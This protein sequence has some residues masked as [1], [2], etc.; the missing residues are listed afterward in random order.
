VLVALCM[1]SPPLMPRERRL[2]KRGRNRFKQESAGPLGQAQ[3]RW[4]HSG[5]T[6]GAPRRRM[7]PRDRA[8]RAARA[9]QEE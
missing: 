3:A 7:R 2:Q 1:A 9:G 4:K 5:R 6:R 8:T